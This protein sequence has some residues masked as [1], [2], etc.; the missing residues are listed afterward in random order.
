M[1]P[2]RGGRVRVAERGR[3]AG[4]VPLLLIMGIGGNLDM[5][6]PLESALGGG[7]HTVSYDAP[8]TGASTGPTVPRRMPG[9][10]R[11]AQDVLDGLG[12][13]R[14][15]VMGVSFGGAVAQQLAVQAPHRVRRLVLAATMPGLGGVPGDPRTLLRMST[16][17]RYW[18]KRYYRRVAPT[19]YGGAVRTDPS[20]LAGAA[21]ARFT[22]PPTMAGYASQLWAI[23]GWTSMPWLHRLTQPTLVLHGDDDP[24]VPLRN[25]R[26][27]ARRVP[28]AR[29]Q[30]LDGAG[31]L[32][33]LERADDTAAALMAFL[34]D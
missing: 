18:S 34:R 26:I 10:A 16:P 5:W 8:G 23:G 33:I 22:R 20:L 2:V 21:Y 31:H 12:H 11:V 4:G 24:I 19:L 27:L 9:L 17:L 28:D 29:L 25:A 7:L 13:E 1:L 14:V 30:V 3:A 32:F 15:D 6:R